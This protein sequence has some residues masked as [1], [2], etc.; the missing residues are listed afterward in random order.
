MTVRM[1]SSVPPSLSPTATSDPS[2]DG[3]Y[4]SIATAASAARCAGS[5]SVRAGASLSTADRTTSENWSAPTPRS[6]TNNRSPRTAAPPTVGSA[7][8]AERRSCHGSQVGRASSACLVRSLWAATQAATSSESPSSS[9]RYGSATA[10]PCRTST[11]TP[12]RVD[13]AGG[14]EAAGGTIGS[15]TSH[16]GTLAVVGLGAAHARLLLLRLLRH[17]EPG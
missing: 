13:G 14:V 16:V 4:Q 1:L 8:S 11:S 17:G 6:S 2:G 5:S 15:A 7:V 3:S 12:R 10:T 9:H